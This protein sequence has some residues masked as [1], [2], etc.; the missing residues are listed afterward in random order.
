MI[1]MKIGAR[2]EISFHIQDIEMIK[3]A[4][5]TYSKSGGIIHEKEVFHATAFPRV[6]TRLF[7]ITDELKHEIIFKEPVTYRGYF[8]IKKKVNKVLVYIEDSDRFAHI[9]EQKIEDIEGLV[10]NFK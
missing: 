6:L 10:T 1:E 4:S 2:R 3:R 5:I 8:G 7:E 9:L